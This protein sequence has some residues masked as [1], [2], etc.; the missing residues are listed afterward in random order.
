M[1]NPCPGKACAI[2]CRSLHALKDTGIAMLNQDF[3]AQHDDHDT[4]KREMLERSLMHAG[5][6]NNS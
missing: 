4:H 5:R 6:G 2:L 1:K 3:F